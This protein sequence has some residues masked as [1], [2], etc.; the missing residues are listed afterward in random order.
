VTFLFDAP[1]AYNGTQSLL[2]DFS[3]NNATYTVSGLAR[4]TMVPQRRS[5]F[6]Q[7]DSAFGDP[8]SWSGTYPPGAMTNRVPNVRFVTESVVDMIPSGAVQI[9]DGVWSG[10]VTVRQPGTNIFLRASDDFGHIANGNQFVV[11]PLAPGP[12]GEPPG[13]NMPAIKSVRLQGRE[14]IIRFS[15]TAGHSYQLERTE[16]LGALHWTPVG[17]SVA[18]N[19]LEHEWM[20]P[21]PP[22]SGNAFY[23]LRALR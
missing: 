9:V 16:D 18:G 23:R 1:F 7:T 6:L 20:D 8:L 10:L 14:F 21:N 3:F 22:A 19:G 17:E 13:A 4:S 11:L 15:T 5:V 12:A 2:V